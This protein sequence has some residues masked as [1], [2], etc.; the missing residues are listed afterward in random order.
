M[1]KHLINIKDLTKAEI[2][3]ILDNAGKFFIENNNKEH[4]DKP[5][6][7]KILVNFFFEKFH[8]NQNII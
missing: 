4:N 1:S 7:S 2:E 8:Q 6:S 3:N 5:P